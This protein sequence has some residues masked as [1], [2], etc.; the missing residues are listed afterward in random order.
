MSPQEQN[1]KESWFFQALFYT[2]DQLQTQQRTV[3]QELSYD[4]QSR[5]QLARDLAHHLWEQGLLLPPQTSLSLKDE[6]VFSARRSIQ[7]MIS[8]HLFFLC[9]R[10]FLTDQI[11]ADLLEWTCRQR[12][13]YGEEQKEEEKEETDGSQTT[14]SQMQFLRMRS[15]RTQRIPGGRKTPGPSY[16]SGWHPPGALPELPP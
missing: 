13:W 7:H 11:P 5:D 3:L 6:N 1:K 10:C 4:C 14:I 2:M 12:G 8:E 15:T 9:I 16:R